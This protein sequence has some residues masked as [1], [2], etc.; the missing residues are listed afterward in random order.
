M[1]Q[2]RINPGKTVSKRRRHPRSPETAPATH[3]ISPLDALVKGLVSIGERFLKGGRAQL[4]I[5]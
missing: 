3:S 4:R 5:P 1:H 2:P